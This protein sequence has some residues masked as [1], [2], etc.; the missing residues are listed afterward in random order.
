[1]YALIS[2]LD[3]AVCKGEEGVDKPLLV[4]FVCAFGLDRLGSRNCSYWRHDD[5]DGLV[6]DV[7][8]DDGELQFTE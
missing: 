4:L 6:I 8:T 3:H 2:K 5:V 1:M 7:S